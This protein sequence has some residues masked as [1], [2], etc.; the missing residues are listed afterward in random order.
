MD[1]GAVSLSLSFPFNFLTGVT[2]A[3][4]TSLRSRK[5]PEVLK[6]SE[7]FPEPI[8]WRVW[9]FRPLSPIF[10]DQ[11][12]RRAHQ[13]RQEKA[14]LCSYLACQVEPFLKWLFILLF[15]STNTAAPD[16]RRTY[17]TFGDLPGQ[18][19]QL[20]GVKTRAS[21]FRPSVKVHG[22]INYLPQQPLINRIYS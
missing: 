1:T 19:H 7:I 16:Y 5:V 4:S 10:V 13:V 8:L 3:G 15:Y 11:T 21:I 18:S 22:A 2:R 20:Q 9:V 12:G 14:K 6:S 17:F